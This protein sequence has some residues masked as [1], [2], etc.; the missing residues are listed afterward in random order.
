[1]H[2]SSGAWGR[3]RPPATLRAGIVLPAAAKRMDSI[4]YIRKWKRGAL[5]CR[6]TWNHP[7]TR[8]SG[9]PGVLYFHP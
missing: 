8:L 7:E 2:G 5:S 4:Q 9:H 6:I 1:M 3:K